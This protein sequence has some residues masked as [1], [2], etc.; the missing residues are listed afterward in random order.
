ME[1]VSFSQEQCG[2]GDQ[3]RH[4]NGGNYHRWKE[5]W[6]D[7]VDRFL[8]TGTTR[9]GFPGDRW[10]SLW[11]GPWNVIRVTEEDHHLMVEI[12]RVQGWVSASYQELAEL[13]MSGLTKVAWTND[14]EVD[15]LPREEVK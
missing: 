13:V 8:V 3:I 10:V 11:E 15:V 6:S 14:G 7:G 2:C 9:E 5:I 12:L 1:L 4:S